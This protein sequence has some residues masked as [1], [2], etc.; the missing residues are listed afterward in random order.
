VIITDT[1]L[2]ELEAAHAGGS[3]CAHAIHDGYQERGRESPPSILA[4]IGGYR[5]PLDMD[6]GT[7]RV[8]V[9]RLGKVIWPDDA[10]V[11]W[12]CNVHNLLESVGN[13]CIVAHSETMYL[14]PGMFIGLKQAMKG[15]KHIG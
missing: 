8:Q 6:G 14:R 7:V 15:V 10:P 12:S 11:D 3:D 13:I 5:I 2:A 1:E 4:Q 9:N